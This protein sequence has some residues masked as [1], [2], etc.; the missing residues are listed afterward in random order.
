MF[1]LHPNTGR[2]TQVSSAALCSTFHCNLRSDTHVTDFSFSEYHFGERIE[3]LRRDI[4]NAPFHYF[5]QHSN[6]ARYFCTGLNKDNETDI[7]QNECHRSGNRPF[8]DAVVGLA[9][10]YAA[11][12]SSLIYCLDNN[13]AEQFNSVV[14]QKVNGKRA[15]YTQRGGINTRG[16]AA[17]VSLNASGRYHEVIHKTHLGHATIGNYDVSAL[18]LEQHR[19]AASAVRRQQ[20]GEGKGEGG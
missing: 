2:R 10:H 15:N 16:Y 17:V 3:K 5:G 20:P 18:E 8:W 13:L 9:N 11:Y 12:A 4:I 7:V 6:C 1:G 14:C 19:C